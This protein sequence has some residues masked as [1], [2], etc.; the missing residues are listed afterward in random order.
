MYVGG[1]APPTTPQ[2]RDAAPVRILWCSIFVTV[3]ACAE[4]WVTLATQCTACKGWRA[5]VNLTYSPHSVK[6]ASQYPHTTHDAL[7]R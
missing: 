6:T 1:Y 2:Q 5:F 3:K 7:P 4:L